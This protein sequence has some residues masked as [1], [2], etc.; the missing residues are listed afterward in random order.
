MYHSSLPLHH[1]LCFALCL[2]SER[3]MTEVSYP[4]S[5]V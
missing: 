3:V 4:E 2:A 5:L 1:A